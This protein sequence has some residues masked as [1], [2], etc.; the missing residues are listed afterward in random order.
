MIAR[1]RWSSLIILKIVH[2]AIWGFGNWSSQVC[3]ICCV[4]T[5]LTKVVYYPFD[6]LVYLKRKLKGFPSSENVGWEEPWVFLALWGRTWWAPE[7]MVLQ[8][9]TTS[10]GRLLCLTCPSL[11]WVSYLLKDIYYCFKRFISPWYSKAVLKEPCCWVIVGSAACGLW[12]TLYSIWPY[13]PAHHG[14]CLWHVLS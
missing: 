7:W 9:K 5:S 11:C 14:G 10:S 4:C 2:S 13:S 12:E 8:W 1:Q 3:R 6:L